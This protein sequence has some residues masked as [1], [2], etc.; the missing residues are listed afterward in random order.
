VRLTLRALLLTCA[1]TPVGC[2]SLGGIELGDDGPDRFPDDG[3]DGYGPS[4]ATA[5]PTRGGDESGSDGSTGTSASPPGM[6]DP[7]GSDDGASEGTDDGEGTEDG[8]ASS[9]GGSGAPDDEST[10]D[11][12]DG[13]SG[14]ESD[15]GGN[16]GAGTNAE[17]PDAELPPCPPPCEIDV[18]RE[19]PCGLDCAM[20]V[21]EGYACGDASGAGMT[22]EA[23]VWVC[24]EP[25]LP[26][27]GCDIVCD[28]LPA[29]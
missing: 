15:G 16:E 26:P 19:R 8:E 4:S 25:P 28:P 24:F 23:G 2:S 3:D 6:L 17:C 13:A 29:A 27:E 21:D 11:P 18:E 14:S 1:I 12:D 9:S 5:D 7:G 20:D 10:G 22:C